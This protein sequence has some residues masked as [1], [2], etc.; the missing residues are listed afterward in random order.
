L[1]KIDTDGKHITHHP[2][3]RTLQKQKRGTVRPPAGC[4][5]KMGDK[6]CLAVPAEPE[7][8][9]E[10][11]RIISFPPNIESSWGIPVETLSL[12][13]VCLN[14]SE[15]MGITVI[16]FSSIRKGNSLVSWRSRGI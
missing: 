13:T 7:I 14:P 10:L 15:V 9:T 5:S 3:I 6:A 4:I 11:P 1:L 8:R 16:P 12:V 2:V